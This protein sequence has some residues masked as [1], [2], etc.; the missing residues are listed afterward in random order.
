MHINDN[1]YLKPENYHA[2]Y[3]ESIDKMAQQNQIEFDKL[4]WHVFML[5]EDGKK[6]LEIFRDKFIAQPTPGQSHA[7]YDKMCIYF[8]GYRQ[9]F[10]DLMMS[11]QAYQ[12]RKDYEAKEIQTKKAGEKIV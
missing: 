8:E 3:Q 6:L 10:R 2:G 11:V 1:P 9:A 7:N 5:N 12:E 4:C